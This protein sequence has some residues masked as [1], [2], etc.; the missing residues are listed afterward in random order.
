MA[1]AYPLDK[2]QHA[3]HVYRYL[4]SDEAGQTHK[5]IEFIKQK[6]E[7]LVDF[8]RFIAEQVYL[9]RAKDF[10]EPFK[11]IT[12]RNREEMEQVVGNADNNSFVQLLR[13][14]IGFD[15]ER[16]RKVIKRL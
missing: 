15:E 5:K 1:A 7:T 9:S 2:A 8:S 14:K 6:L 13:K 10:N 3:W 16:V 4:Y 11:S 12:Y